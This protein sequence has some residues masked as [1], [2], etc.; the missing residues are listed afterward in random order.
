MSAKLIRRGWLLRGIEVELP[1]GAH[2][3]EYNGRGFGFEQVSIDSTMICRR[4]WHWFVPR[5]EFKLGGYPAT[6]EVRVRP[7]FALRSLVLQLG[8]RVIYAEG[9]RI[10]SKN[11]V[12]S[13]WDEL[14]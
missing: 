10:W 12:P 8:G 13:D 9:I 1:D 3:V 7:W 6:V 14:A 11:E 4:S 2:F 5:F